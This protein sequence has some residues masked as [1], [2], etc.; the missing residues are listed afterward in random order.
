M[1]LQMSILQKSRGTV[2]A[3]PTTGWEQEAEDRRGATKGAGAELDCITERLTARLP[4]DWRP[5]ASRLELEVAGS[6]DLVSLRVKRRRPGS[7]WRCTVWTRGPGGGLLV[8]DHRHADPV[9]A[10]G[11]ALVQVEDVVMRLEAVG[12]LAGGGDDV[13]R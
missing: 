2:Q 13:R 11:G 5:S 12:A 4:A 7:P 6:V 3:D 10:L 8:A 1:A 9:R